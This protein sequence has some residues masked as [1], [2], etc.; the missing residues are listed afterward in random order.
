MLDLTS[1][2]KDFS[3]MPEGYVYSLSQF[4]SIERFQKVCPFSN[5]I[6]TAAQKLGFKV[7][8]YIDYN[9]SW[10]PYQQSIFYFRSNTG[11][12]ENDPLSIWINFSIFLHEIN[13]V[14]ALEPV[15]DGLF[16]IENE[17]DFVYLAL[18]GEAASFYISDNLLYI[19]L[20]KLG[21]QACP[22]MRWSASH[23]YYLPH[24]VLS[25]YGFSN[26]RDQLEIYFGLY[27]DRVIPKILMKSKDKDLYLTEFIGRHFAFGYW[28][29][30]TSASWYRTYFAQPEVKKWFKDFSKSSFKNP[31]SALYKKSNDKQK[32]YKNFLVTLV[33]K[34]VKKELALFS[35]QKEISLMREIRREALWNVNIRHY[36]RSNHVY[37]S[38][39]IAISA[40]QKIFLIDYFKTEYAELQ[41]QWNK[42]NEGTRLQNVAKNIAELLVAR[43]SALNKHLP[44][45][46]LYG[47]Y[48]EGARTHHRFGVPLSSI[49]LTQLEML[50]TPFD[51]LYLGSGLD[52]AIKK[53]TEEVSHGKTHFEKTLLTLLSLKSAYLKCCPN[54]KQGKVGR[55][56]ANTSK[57]LSAIQK[58]FIKI[59]KDQ[60]SPLVLREVTPKLLSYSQKE[61]LIANHIVGFGT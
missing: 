21:D 59:I 18:L 11:A 9:T 39:G 55:L 4:G 36:L 20:D 26:W 30:K 41:S 51:I 57:K 52:M 10:N 53:L 61:E 31:V 3:T 23:G 58:K 6:I 8:P 46:T 24:I 17:E 25:Q 15:M 49:S 1:V 48:N 13:H 22:L 35:E 44:P 5:T 47:G 16:E 34:I 12:K 45:T 56:N 14:L 43:K 42:I 60:I 54:Y 33:N 32:D 40:R 50:E 28:G 38:K 27:I 7:Y 29:K 37:D 19:E 2:K